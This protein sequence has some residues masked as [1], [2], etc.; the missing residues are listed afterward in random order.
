VIG[1]LIGDM[2]IDDPNIGEQQLKVRIEGTKAILENIYPKVEIRLNGKVVSGSAEIHVR[3]NL[4]VGKTSISFSRLD[5]KPAAPAEPFEH[6]NA[7]TRFAPGTSEKAILSALHF[8][9]TNGKIEPPQPPGI[10]GRPPG[11]PPKPKSPIPPPFKK[12]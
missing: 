4:N 2:I 3:D 9:A 7:A 5:D 12:A 1:S 8:L 10:S 11:L 6:P